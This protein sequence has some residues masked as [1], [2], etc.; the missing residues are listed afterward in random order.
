MRGGTSASVAMLLAALSVAASL[1]AHAGR[2]GKD[3]CYELRVELGS[4]RSAGAEEDMK[5]G[6]GWGKINLTRQELQNV[7]RLV[8]VEEQLRFRCG[9][10]RGRLVAKKPKVIPPPDMPMRKPALA[11]ANT[12]KTTPI[13]KKSAAAPAAKKVAAPTPRIRASSRQKRKRSRA[14]A[15]TPSEAVINSL[16]PYSSFR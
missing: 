7:H 9:S 14:N 11:T 12:R 2:L 8:E 5:L 1:P 13:G 15:Y 6:P 16:N 4:L 10:L 3:A